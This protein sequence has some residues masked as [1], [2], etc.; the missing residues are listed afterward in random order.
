MGIREHLSV[1]EGRDFV[2]EIHDVFMARHVFNA[3]VFST[4]SNEHIAL[5]F[6]VVRIGSVEAYYEALGGEAPRPPKPLELT[7]VSRN[8]GE[9]KEHGLPPEWIRTVT[10]Q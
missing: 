4:V 9:Y 7:I 6:D 10:M 1:G 3:Q 5:V 8:A 2:G